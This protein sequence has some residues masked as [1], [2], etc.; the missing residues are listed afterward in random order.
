MPLIIFE[1]GPMPVEKKRDL[2]RS[3]ADAASQVTGI[4]VQAFVTIIHENAGENIGTGNELLADRRA[5]ETA[6]AKRQA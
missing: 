6:A 2:V 1:A 3:L 5:R 4:P